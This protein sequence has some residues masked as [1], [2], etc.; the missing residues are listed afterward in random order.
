MVPRTRS[1]SRSTGPPQSSSRGASRT[2]ST[3]TSPARRSGR[4]PAP[5]RRVQFPDIP[6]EDP[7]LV[8]KNR[9]GKK[10]KSPPKGPK[11][12]PKSVHTRWGPTTVRG[13][14]VDIEACEKQD[15]LRKRQAQEAAATKA[16]ANRA[17]VEE[18]ERRLEIEYQTRESENRGISEEHEE[19]EEEESSSSNNERMLDTDNELDALEENAYRRWQA[20]P[21]LYRMKYNLKALLPKGQSR[22]IASSKYGEED[23]VE[24]GFEPEKLDIEIGRVMEQKGFEDV[25]EDIRV[26]VKS[27]HAKAVF[28]RASLESLDSEVWNKRVE[29]ILVQEHSRFPS[30]KLNVTVDITGRLQAQPK[31][32][33]GDV[34]SPS[35]SPSHRRTR[36][37][38]LEEQLRERRDDNEETGDYALE[39]TNRLRC[40]NEKCCNE[41]NFCWV[42]SGERKHYALSSTQKKAWGQ[43]ITNGVH[44]ASLDQPPDPMKRWLIN[45]AGPVSSKSRASTATLSREEKAAIHEQEREEQ[46]E[47]DADRDRRMNRMFDMQMRA[48]ELKAMKVTRLSTGG[49]DQG[50]AHP[51]YQQ[52]SGP[53]PPWQQFSQIPYSPVLPYQNPNPPPQNPIPPSTQGQ[54]PPTNAP[55]AP[56]A[57]Q[58]PERVTRSSP[59]AAERSEAEQV[60]DDFWSWRS[61]LT[62]SV[63]RRGALAEIKAIVDKEMWTVEDLRTMSDPSTRMYQRGLA[64]GLPEGMMEHFDEDFREFKAVYRTQYK[65]ARQLAD[66][67]RPYNAAS[68]LDPR[69]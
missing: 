66:M 51:P 3:S 67:Q 48:E 4:S 23:F 10:G 41:G 43:A 15:A 54:P 52:W 47:R 37:I 59:I 14:V 8:K 11:N 44:G 30:Y 2:A 16:A 27:D 29:S 34:D 19:E 35:K 55:T 21:Y 60:M 6:D 53:P 40:H 25:I 69:L 62:R 56:A 32:P 68:L 50:L 57:T 58:L 63:E 9:N 20:Q 18:E 22:T 31:R 39:L 42:P 1:N 61:S 12:K 65:P 13:R 5:N 17:A 33:L 36:T 24:G 46:R 38:T 28:E 64:K 45:T 7:D 49:D 26:S